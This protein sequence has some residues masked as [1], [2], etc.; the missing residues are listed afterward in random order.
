MALELFE[1]NFEQF[2]KLPS[3]KSAEAPNREERRRLLE[4]VSKQGLH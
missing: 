4:A 2:I 3:R 1:M